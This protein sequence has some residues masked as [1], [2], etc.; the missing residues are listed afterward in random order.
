MSQEEI[1]SVSAN[2]FYRSN[3]LPACCFQEDEFASVQGF[4]FGLVLSKRTEMK[5]LSS[6]TASALKRIG[7]VFSSLG[8]K[9]SRKK[10]EFIFWFF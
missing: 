10:I 5:K 6:S 1:V 7:T 8:E 9:E 3:P 2:V 4:S